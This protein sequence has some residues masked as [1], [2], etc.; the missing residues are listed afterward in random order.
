MRMNIERQFEILVESRERFKETV[1]LQADVWRGVVPTVL[2]HEYQK[3]IHE[4]KTGGQ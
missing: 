2:L 4:S 3:Y 1:G